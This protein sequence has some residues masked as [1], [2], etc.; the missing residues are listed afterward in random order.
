MAGAVSAGSYTAGVM[1]YLLEILERWEEQKEANRKALNNGTS[2]PFPE[3]P[4]HN[5]QIDVLSGA[6]A[7][8]MCAAI[9]ANMFAQGFS[10]DELA[11]KQSKL[12]KA[13]IELDDDAQQ[14]NTF[15]KM[16]DTGDIKS[17]NLASLLNSEVIER[18]AAKTVQA[19]PNP[20]TPPYVSAQMDILLTIANLQGVDVNINFHGFGKI[21]NHSMTL[22]RDFMH[23]RMNSLPSP[24]SDFLPI[25]F[26]DANQ[27][28]LL[29]DSAIATGAF[30]IGLRAKKL[31]RNKDYVRNKTLNTIGL[32]PQDLPA[33][34]QISIDDNQDEISTINVD[35]GTFNNEPF[36]ETE[37]LLD[38]KTQS[39]SSS[40]TRR[41]YSLIMIDPFPSIETDTVENTDNE[42]IFSL[43][44]QILAALREQSLFREKDII[45]ALESDNY[46][47]FLIHPTKDNVKNA[48]CCSALGAFGGFLHKGFRLHDYQLGRRNAQRFLQKHFALPFD[49]QNPLSNHP[50]HQS[51]SGCAVKKHIV[52]KDGKTLLP[53]IPDVRIHL[54]EEP[55]P[56][57]TT[58]YR[59]TAQKLFA[60]EAP[61]G[62]RIEAIVETIVQDVTA[63]RSARKGEE[64][65]ILNQFFKE[66]WFDKF[67]EKPKRWTISITAN[68]AKPLIVRKAKKALL[69][70]MVLE[71]YKNN[72]IKK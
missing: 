34:I 58:E 22:H 5:V 6:S 9:T 57:A 28:G 23:F 43:A 35:G 41:N 7:G 45:H 48:L 11:T 55:S 70:I 52:N 53:I 10:I 13:W 51:W 65:K 69:K 63:K 37:R 36:G 40:S 71:L 44:K 14:D 30:P 12:Y 29:R 25:D 19:T 66:S 72:L 64:E 32:D 42:G 31:T 20:K 50:I 3:I 61:I 38:S 21:K 67:M 59:M 54:H 8:G 62:L 16:L 60:M 18:I 1:D 47:K 15:L 4:M 24:V 56:D 17:N 2:L 39:I 27:V 68:I 26:S 49:V 46:A 33:T